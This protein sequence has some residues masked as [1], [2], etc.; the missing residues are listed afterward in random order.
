MTSTSADPT[1]STRSASGAQRASTS[2]ARSST[3]SSAR[4]RA[5][6]IAAARSPRPKAC[7]ARTLRSRSVR[8]ATSRPDSSGPPLRGPYPA[9][10]AD[11]EHRQ[12]R[13]DGQ[14]RRARASGRCATSSA[15]TT[16]SIE[17]VGHQR[18]GHRDQRVQ[19]PADVGGEPGDQ[20]AAAHLVVP[21]QRPGHR[22]VEHG[23]AQVGT[24]PL[25]RALGVPLRR[26]VQQS[27]QTAQR[28]HGASPASTR[29]STGLEMPTTGMRHRS[30][31]SAWSTASASGHG[32]SEHGRG[33]QQHQSA[34]ERPAGHCGP[35][36]RAA[37]P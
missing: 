13:N 23:R 22:V 15:R 37:R 4:L 29:I 7:T 12:H 20:L 33:P 35:G 8:R 26:H 14:A 21:A 10:L 32:L 28:D 31:V 36:G 5:P 17:H 1:A 11:R 3:S 18:R 6:K 27:E 9:P 2:T 24:D 30:P 16:S 34:G 19:Q 25:G